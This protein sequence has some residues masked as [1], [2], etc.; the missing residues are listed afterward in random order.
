MQYFVN[1]QQNRLFDPFKGLFSSIAVRML[2]E[3]WQGTPTS[4]GHV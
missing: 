1:P 4:V 2:S 3:G